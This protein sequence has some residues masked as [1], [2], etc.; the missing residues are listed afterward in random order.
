M[1]KRASI[2]IFVCIYKIFN[3]P[4]YIPSTLNDNFMTIKAKKHTNDVRVCFFFFFTF[5]VIKLS[6][7][8]WRSRLF[9]KG[10]VRCY[11]LWLN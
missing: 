3:V 6:F 2:S 11:K 8:E 4:L 1:Y 7:K 10:C 9:C 5:I